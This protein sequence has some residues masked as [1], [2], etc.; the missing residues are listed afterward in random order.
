MLRRRLTAEQKAAIP[1]STPTEEQ[2][3]SI[4]VSY[5]PRT[6]PGVQ[7]CYAGVD[8]TVNQACASPRCRSISGNRCRA[9]AT[10]G[11]CGSCFAFASAFVYS[12][13]L[14][15]TTNYQ[16]NVALAEQD[17]VSCFRDYDNFALVRCSAAVYASCRSICGSDA[18]GSWLIG[19]GGKSHRHTARAG[20]WVRRRQS[21]G[22]L[23]RN[24]DDG[25]FDTR[26]QQARGRRG[27]SWTYLS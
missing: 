10:Q 25:L 24:A 19:F 3:Q 16:T 22:R 23:D 26:L 7:K 9:H 18:F 14:C 11:D 2:L 1:I 5:D 20:Q 8:R 21:G 6:V 12:V 13:R 27:I 15:Q 17:V 4:P